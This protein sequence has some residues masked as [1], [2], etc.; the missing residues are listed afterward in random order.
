V[1]VPPMQG[2]RP[3][4]AWFASLLS[5]VRTRTTLTSVP[6]TLH[7]CARPPW[8]P[9]EQ[10]WWTR[11]RCMV[12]VPPRDGSHA[13]Y[14]GFAC[15]PGL[16]GTCSLPRSLAIEPRA[17]AHHAGFTRKPCLGGSC[18]ML[19][20]GPV[21]RSSCTNH[22]WFVREQG[23]PR[24]RTIRQGLASQAVIA[25]E[26]CEMSRGSCRCQLTLVGRGC[27]KPS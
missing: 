27:C 18:T 20:H 23:I 12:H 26:P 11:P 3:C 13:S 19:P 25:R 24:T 16:M 22:G 9:H 2:A 10:A 14:V 5:M 6:P 17:R 1:R 8:E 15:L 7:G 4:Y 21:S